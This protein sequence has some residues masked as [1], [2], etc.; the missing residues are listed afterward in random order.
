MDKRKVLGAVLLSVAASVWGGMFVVVKSIVTEIPPVELVWLR[1]L[2]GVIVL[3]IICLASRIKWHWDRHNLFLIFLIGLIGSTISIVTQETGTWLSSAQLGSVITA[4]TPTFMVLFSWWLLKKRPSH[5]DLIGLVLSGIGVLVIVGVQFKGKHILTGTLLLV[6]AALTW[7]LMSVI[8]Q[9]V[10]QKYDVLQITFLA[11]VVAVIC[12]TPWVL[13]KDQSVIMAI[14]FTQPHVF[15]SILY[16][17]AIS[18]SLGFAF[19]NKGLQLMDSNTAG[20][21]FLFQ[22]IVGTLLGWLFLGEA[23]SWGFVVGTAL[24]FLS[25]WVSIKWPQTVAVGHERLE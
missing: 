24:I 12:L 15:L 1:Y 11:A 22:P 7:A 25:I 20:L 16:L 8:I 17:G 14:H 9:M 5:G 18:T 4:A 21:F 13:I 2:S 3:L 23:I 6:I 10:D 19:W